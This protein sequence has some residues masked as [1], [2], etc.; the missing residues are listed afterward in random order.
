MAKIDSFL[1]YFLIIQRL[2]GRRLTFEELDH[3]L[4]TES[5]IQGYNLQ[6]SQ[7]TFQRNILEIASMFHIHIECDKSD[8]RYY[9]KEDENHAF[10]YRMLDAFN[11]FNYLSVAGKVQSCILTEKRRPQGTEHMGKLLNAIKKQHQ[12]AFCYQKYWEDEPTTREAEP[13]ALKEFKGRWYLLACDK[14]DNKIK[15]FGL[16]RISELQKTTKSFSLPE[17]YDP[18][19][20]FQHAFGIMN[21]DD[22]A[23]EEVLLSFK[24]LQGNYI[25][26]Y[27][28]HPSQ[29]V[30][31]DNEEEF[32]IRLTLHITHDFKMELLSYGA[33]VKVLSPERL[34]EEL[35]SVY[36]AALE[37]YT[38]IAAL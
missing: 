8:Y 20:L 35:R 14:K 27:P 4:E 24:R 7:R 29:Q 9:I 19:T 15:T 22:Q 6:V 33:N 31:T 18:E 37:Q 38:S 13:L 11:V 26:S 25:R 36:S 32:C 17:G 23:P 10:G 16:D 30:L 21:H 34:Q 2:R 3:F 5:E 28:L 12:V 1:R